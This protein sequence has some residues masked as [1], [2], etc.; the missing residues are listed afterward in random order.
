[1]AELTGTALQ[2]PKPTQ[3]ARTD[4]DKDVVPMRE[5]ALDRQERQA[6]MVWAQEP[7]TAS[8]GAP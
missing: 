7:C 1:M 4:Q 6:K 3:G 2:G 5:A 8:P